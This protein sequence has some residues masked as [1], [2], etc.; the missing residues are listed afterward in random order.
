MGYYL[1]ITDYAGQQY[2]RRVEKSSK[3]PYHIERSYKIVFHPVKE[4]ERPKRDLICEQARKQRSQKKDR[5]RKRFSRE[6]NPV[7]GK[8]ERINVQI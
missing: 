1:P 7:E 6:L 4:D 5:K 2:R 8:G 3:S